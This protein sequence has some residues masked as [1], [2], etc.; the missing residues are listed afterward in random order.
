MS[1]IFDT[2]ASYKKNHYIIDKIVEEWNS[3]EY[4]K[5]VDDLHNLIW[6]INPASGS[7][8]EKAVNYAK[9]SCDEFFRLSKLGILRANK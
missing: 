8:L 6:R 4:Q 1:K 7:L 2:E 3:K 9:K 5:M